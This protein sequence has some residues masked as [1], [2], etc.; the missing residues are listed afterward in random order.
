MTSI[1][2]DLH[3]KLAGDGRGNIRG[4]AVAD[5]GA[6]STLIRC[7]PSVRSQLA[8]DTLGNSGHCRRPRP[9]VRGLTLKR[10]YGLLS[11][12]PAGLTPDKPCTTCKLDPSASGYLEVILRGTWDACQ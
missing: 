7:A 9:K 11:S 1:A 10:T 3:G 4:E 5:G 8:E 6:Q 2:R 12:G